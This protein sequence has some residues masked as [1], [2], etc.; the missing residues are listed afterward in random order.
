MA[1]YRAKLPLPHQ[2]PCHTLFVGHNPSLSTW[3]TGRFF[4]NPSNRF[5]VLIQES[6]LNGVQKVESDDE[7]V[8]RFGFGFCDVLELP[9]NNAG[10]ID[11]REM[12]ANIPVFLKRIE[13][14]ATSMNGSL[15]RICFVGKRQW[16]HLF[17][18]PLSRCAHGQLDK[19]ERPSL[20]P[21]QFEGIEVWILPSPSGRA[22]MNWEQRLAPY[23]DLATRINA[24][25]Q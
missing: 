16:K 15:K 11:K 5:W 6:G 12:V 23:I 24:T 25:E 18:P 9:G 7:M 2:P 8:E 13:K 1:A 14:Y 17:T 10:A 21:G 20:W 19:G 3:E 22:V 4:A